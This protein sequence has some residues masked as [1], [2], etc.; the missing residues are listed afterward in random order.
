LFD[1]ACSFERFRAKFDKQNENYLTGHIFY[2]PILYREDRDKRT[3]SPD[4]LDITGNT[5][6]IYRVANTEIQNLC[7]DNGFLSREELANA[8]I[9]L[10]VV[11]YGRLSN[12][13]NCFFDRMSRHRNNTDSSKSIRDEFCSIKKPGRKCRKILSTG[14]IGTLGDVSTVKTFFRL[15]TVPYIGDDNFAENVSWWNYN[16]LP[17]RIRM[18]AFKFYNNI[19]GLNTRTS[20][21]A[22]NPT[23]ACTFCSI[24]NNVVP[25]PDESFKHLFLDCPTVKNWQAMFVQV[26][27]GGLPLS[28]V[29][30][31]KFWFLGLLP[32]D[33]K[34]NLAVLTAVLIFQYCIWEE[35]LRKRCPS[36]TTISTLFNDQNSCIFDSSLV[37]R[38]AASNLAFPLYRPHWA[39]RVQ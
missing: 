35:K 13:F 4:Y 25:V 28:E 23:R 11:G 6:L 32:R 9:P 2:N 21:F 1:I 20:H 8:D 15:L 39:L 27:F 3:L 17:N 24:K 26:N 5:A 16:I 29:E 34:P 22:V 30:N 18:F 14:R 12:A 10:S 19:L 7:G 31:I 33:L 38:E 37:H 36:F